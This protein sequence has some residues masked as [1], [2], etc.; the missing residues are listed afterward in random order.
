MKQLNL[1]KFVTVIH[2]VSLCR[3]AAILRGECIRKQLV[4]SRALVKKLRPYDSSYNA[5]SSQ[6]NIVL[7][8]AYFHKGIGKLIA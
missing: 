8:I 6:F 4:S 3:D 5:A 2:C 1:E 7:L